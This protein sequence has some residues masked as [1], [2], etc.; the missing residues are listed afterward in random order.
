MLGLLIEGDTDNLE[1]GFMEFYEDWSTSQVEAWAEENGVDL[2]E[3]TI[4]L[5]QGGASL[6]DWGDHTESWDL[7][8]KEELCELISSFSNDGWKGDPS[9]EEALF[10]YLENGHF[11][12]AYL[13]SFEDAYIGK[14]ETE[15]QCALELNEELISAVKSAG[16][17]VNFIDEY[18]LA[19]ER[20][21]DYAFPVTG[22][23]HCF[24]NT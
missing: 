8:E 16:Y 17:D 23:V 22:G 13:D 3:C 15:Q 4:T 14:F 20:G 12:Y 21:A 1:E 5:T 10:L 19:K 11:N 2:S 7:S 24:R 6:D 18:Y 9:K